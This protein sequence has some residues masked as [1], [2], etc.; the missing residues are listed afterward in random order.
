MQ[1]FFGSSLNHVGKE[2]MINWYFP[3]RLFRHADGDNRVRNAN[4]C[5]PH[6]AVAFIWIREAARVSRRCLRAT[7]R[8]LPIMR[9]ASKAAR[10][11]SGCGRDMAKKGRAVCKK[12]QSMAKTGRV[13]YK[14]AR[15]ATTEGELGPVF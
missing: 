1:V 2:N 8:C 5:S 9:V 6:T 4:V 14:M 10:I 15:N 11:V 12:G 7:G 13:A 3:T